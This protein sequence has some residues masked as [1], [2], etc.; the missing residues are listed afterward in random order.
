MRKVTAWLFSTVDGVVEAPDQW[1]FDFDEQMGEALGG[2]QE[3]QDTILMGRNTFQMWSGYWPNVTEGEDV[4]FADW[5]N[6]Q[7]K[8]V[9]SSTLDSVDEWKNSTLVKGDDLAGT[10][11]SLKEQDG[12]DI[13]TAG[14]PTLVRSLVD[15]GLLD[16]LTLLIHPVVAGGGRA[17]LFAD[18]AALTKLTLV[19]AKPTSS[20]VIIAS[21]RPAQ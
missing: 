13:G 5:I 14:S 7:P 6:N 20:G 1:Q 11:A 15:Q 2:L 16:E 4:T 9:V 21:Y 3:T 17:R 18:D 8:Y 19:D 10:I 12:K